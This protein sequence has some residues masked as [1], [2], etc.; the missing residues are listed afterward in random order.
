MRESAGWGRAAAWLALALAGG[1]AVL[2][3]IEAGPHV[4]YQHFRPLG[5]AMADRPVELLIVVVQTTV[6]LWAARSLVPAAWR[7]LTRT[8]PPWRLAL[9]VAAFALSS[10]A[11]SKDVVAYAAEIVVA[12][13][14]QLIALL[15]VLLAVRAIPAGAL[16]PLGRRFDR[17]L[18]APAG[19]AVEPG[20]PDRFA[21]LAAAWVV[22]VAAVLAVV[23]Y[24]RHPHIPD[25]VSYL[26]QAR[27]LA[28]GVLAMPA[29]PVPAA[30]NVDLMQYEPTRWFSPFPPGWPALLALGELAGVP[31]LVN[32]VLGGLTVLLAYV[33][34]R[35]LYARR[36]ARVAVLLLA[37]SPWFVFMTMSLM[38]HSF[39]LF[40]TLAAAVA[41]T[42]LRRTGVAWWGWLGGVAIGL[43]S[44]MRP[45]E[46]VVV[47]GLLGLW[48]LVRAG[49]GERRIT[50]RIVPAVHLALGAVLVTVANLPYNARLTGSPTRFPVMAY[51]DAYY[52]PGVNDLGFGANRGVG[53]AGLDPLP[54]HGS[55]DVVINA[56]LNTFAVNVELLGWATGSLLVLALFAL[57]GR[58]RRSDWLMAAAIAAV[59]GVHSLYWFSG[60][61]DFGARYWYLI[62]IPCIAL[63]AR[64]LEWV[65]GALARSGW[66]PPPD[67]EATGAER[68]VRHSG[69][70]RDIEPTLGPAWGADDSLSGVRVL[71]AATALSLLALA[72]FFPWRAA[73][74]YHHYRGMRPDVRTLAREHGFGR[75]VVLVQGR[76]FP[77]YAS[78]VIYNP[79]DL[80]GSSAPVYVWDRNTDT[81]RATLREYGDRPVW[82]V[83]GPSVTGAGYRVL[84]AAMSAAEAEVRAP[85]P[86]PDFDR[87]EGNARG[88]LPAGGSGSAASGEH[89]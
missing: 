81:R 23:S 15:A 11:L 84:G 40:C 82:V 53:W 77:D 45:L 30:F 1:V 89:R 43:V 73:D 32:P 13:A 4:R 42:R 88:V 48:T 64:G 17:M 5:R 85:P 46:G 57:S 74:K 10:A 44:L 36:T 27:Y 14:V 79:L 20:G 86:N 26:L 6:V 29:P 61:P 87:T 75:S 58:M 50:L 3:L 7:W 24:E 34:L 71:A 76:R 52:G 51:F 62:L 69:D 66:G 18:G 55:V 60:G 33:F 38:S 67:F 16:P 37:V 8:Y 21:C 78:A 70:A 63:S 2:R 72:T 80:R 54:G 35:E 39:S 12:T 65:G 25:E 83:Q 31:W 28:H 59:V 49:E 68:D 19:D 47:A 22:A 56:A 9:L 41:V